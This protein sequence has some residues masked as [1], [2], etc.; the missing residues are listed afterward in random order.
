MKVN[1]TFKS[2]D[3][4]YYTCQGM[5]DEEEKQVKEVCRKWIKYGEYLT[6]EVDTDEETIKVLEV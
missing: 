1:L 2:P 6:V 5:S 3:T 4:M